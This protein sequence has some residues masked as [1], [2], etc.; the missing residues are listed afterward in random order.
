MWPWISPNYGLEDQIWICAR[1]T[2]VTDTAISMLHFHFVLYKE[3]TNIILDGIQ[4]KFK[5]PDIY[6]RA[7]FFFFSHLCWDESITSEREEHEGWVETSE[8]SGGE[9][10]Q[11]GQWEQFHLIPQVDS[12]L[13]NDFMIYLCAC[14]GG[15]DNN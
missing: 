7:R 11:W 10:G 1:F 2:S 14:L 15:I 8:T 3:S 12:S 5:K 13:G 6:S 9:N 4:H